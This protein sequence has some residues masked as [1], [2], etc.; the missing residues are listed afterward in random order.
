[1]LL[2]TLIALCTVFTN[3]AISVLASGSGRRAD[4][5][6]CS[7][8]TAAVRQEWGDMTD[9]QR[10]AYIDAVL[11]LMSTPSVYSPGVVPGAKSHFDD[12]MAVHIN[13][14]L[15]IHI[16]G[17]FLPWHREFVRLYEQALQQKCIGTGPG[18]RRS[19]R[20]LSSTAAPPPSPAT[21]LTMRHRVLT[22]LPKAFTSP[23]GTGGGCVTGGPFVN[24]T[25]NFGPF[26]TNDAFEGI[27]PAN[28]QD[29]TPHCFVRDLNDYVANMYGNTTIVDALLAASTIAE[30]QGN[31]TGYPAT[32]A[33]LGPH[34]GIHISLGW[35]LQDFFASPG[36]PAF[37]LHHGMVDRTWALWQEM[38]PENR[39]T[40]LNGTASLGNPVTSPVVT[41]DTVVEWGPL[42]PAKTVGELMDIMSGEYCYRYV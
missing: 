21:V 36:D 16:S 35:A 13:N 41:L 30:F 7:P 14:T 2:K 18:G 5:S 24:H 33:G 12:F 3:L 39:Q 34:P 32:L 29:Y 40:A 27:L 25:I 1:M 15:T 19:L 26:S 9:P 20:A 17:I 11:C 4:T 38:D 22:R 31:M 37:Y 42:G 10:T 23:R 28:W 6:T 8:E